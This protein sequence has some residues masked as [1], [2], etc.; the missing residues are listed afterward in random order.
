MKCP[1]QT[2][3]MGT[4]SWLVVTWGRGWEAWGVT[5]DGLTQ[6]EGG[7][8]FAASLLYVR[9]HPHQLWGPEEGSLHVGMWPHDPPAVIH[10]P[11]TPGSCRQD[12]KLG[13]IDTAVL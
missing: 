7:L 13:V 1:E 3:P 4:E 6:Q 11:S 9:P 8:C 12:R 10:H 5:A 2:K